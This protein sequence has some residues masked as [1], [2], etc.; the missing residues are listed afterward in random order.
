[1]KNAISGQFQ[2]LALNRTTYVTTF[3]LHGKNA[4]LL[5]RVVAPFGQ[6]F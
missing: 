4:Q 1:M 3:D 6:L 5:E 2:Q